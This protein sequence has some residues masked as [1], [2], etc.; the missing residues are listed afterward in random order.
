MSTV[1]SFR[2]DPRLPPWDRGDAE[3]FA[4]NGDRRFRLRRASETEA[5][6]ATC[7]H[8]RPRGGEPWTAAVEYV[9]HGVFVRRFVVG[10]LLDSGEAF[11]RGTFDRA[12]LAGQRPRELD[13][14][15]PEHGRCA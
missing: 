2:R 9:A 3:W 14:D 1:V 7:H 11:A 6:Q 8:G 4:H 12:T 15:Q 10:S 5:R 13:T